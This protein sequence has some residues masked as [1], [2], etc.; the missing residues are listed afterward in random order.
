MET[1]LLIA[2]TSNE[3][4]LGREGLEA[5]AIASKLTAE[6]EDATLKI[7]LIGPSIQPGAD[8]I[9]SCRANKILGVAGPA[10]GQARYVTDAAA[11]EAICRAAAPTLVV[12]PGSSRSSRVAAG[13]AYRLGGRI[14][15][16]VSGVSVDKGRIHV[17]RWYYRQRMRACLTR[18][19]RPW[20]I[21]I[22]SGSVPAW[23]GETGQ[24]AVEL[25]DISLPDEQMQTSVA[26]LLEPLSGEQTIRPEAELL[27]VAGA[28]WTK[29]QPDGRA[30]VAE[31]EELILEFLHRSKASLG[32]S[33]SM[34]DQAGEGHE[35]LPFMTHLN[36][37]GQTGSSPRHLKGLATCCHG[38]EPHAV[39]WRFINERRAVNLDSNC[40][41][42]RGKADVLYVADAFKVMARVNELLSEA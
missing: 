28:G 23:T 41:W 12:V 11:A 7:G 27:F 21:A 2:H 19:H 16:H 35:V 39:G 4:S 26:G 5:L 17:T 18:E 8:Q 30:H 15:T 29:V 36:Q 1:I 42:A 25:L 3:G 33:K 9:A 38:E 10:F 24:G 22:D 6:L 20:F 13:V 32:G 34:V 14:D 31:A 37:I 40:G